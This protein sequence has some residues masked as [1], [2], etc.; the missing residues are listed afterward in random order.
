MLSNSLTDHDSIELPS[1]PQV[2]FLPKQLH[3]AILALQNFKEY[4]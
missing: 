3:H 2:N 4:M 1:I